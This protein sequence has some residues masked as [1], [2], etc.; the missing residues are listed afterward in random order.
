M[1]T[2]AASVHGAGRPGIAGTGRTTLALA[3]GP[4]CGPLVWAAL[5]ATALLAGC[6]SAPAPAPD[7]ALSPLP[8]RFAGAAQASVSLPVPAGGAWWQVF[9]DT[10][11]DALIG[12]ALLH[13]TSL[14]AASANLAR[15]RALARSADAQRLPTVGLQAALDQQ[16]GPLINRAG[17]SGSL[18]SAAV[19]AS[20]EVDLM[21][22]L[23]GQQQAAATDVAAQE[24]LLRSVRLLVQVEV[25]QNHLEQVALADERVLLD[26]AIAQ[27]QIEQALHGRRLLLGSVAEASLA[28]VRIEL[29]Q[30]Q[31]ER[32]ALQRRQDDLAHA[33]ALL[34]GE[35]AGAWSPS[36]PADG[37]SS[38][39]LQTPPQVPP[40]IP[41]QVLVRRP[42]VQ[43][44][45][46]SMRLAQQRLGLTQGEWFPTLTLSAS[47]GL[48]SA[49]LG[50]LLAVSSRAWGLGAL[51]A[52][53][54]F[55][56]GRRDARVAAAAAELDLALAQ[57]R[58]RILVAMRE[59]EDQLTGLQAL[60]RQAV[61]RVDALAAGERAAMLARARVERGMAAQGEWLQA[62]RTH[63]RLR[64]ELLQL[65]H[66]QRQATLA[67][68]RALGG[69]WDA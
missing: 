29:A 15:A 58:E 62:E 4:T 26:A 16:G 10:R 21:G 24:A 1:G 9:G 25:V 38:A 52:L 48:A 37:R 8:A 43:A 35:H 23:A 54:V 28:G 50:D 49:S 47:Q 40:G 53:P 60:E 57:Y 63:Q 27:L 19:G 67:L 30:A 3:A 32:A 64:R 18:W 13:N 68:I 56:G 34:V 7:A 5:A 22:R 2:C 6:A 46:E 12:R 31:A 11:I 20:Y 55:D 36:V 39:A 44:A 69:G 33:Q 65:R 14:Q 42:D 17:G 41:S 45:R 59:V 61:A 66:A 51:L